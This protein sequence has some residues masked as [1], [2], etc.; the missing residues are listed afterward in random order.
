[1]ALSEPKA[2]TPLHR[3]QIT[4]DAFQRADGLTEIEATLVDTKPDDFRL[5]IERPHVP[6][7]EAIHRI[8]VRLAVDAESTIRECEVAMEVTP[9]GYCRE[10]EARFDLTG[11]N[12]GKGFIQ[13]VGER[14]ASA[15]NC[16][17][18]RQL[19]PQMATVLVQ[20][21]YPALRDRI[22]KLPRHER[23]APAMLNTCAGWQSHR[24]HIRIEHADHYR[25]ERAAEPDPGLA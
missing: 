2:R 13:A 18:A 3:R 5:G 22:A 1:M 21:I 4:L 8:A 15:D 20:A 16:W 12:L 7:G 17:H 25:P 11:L 6:A 9:Y 10:V 14:L 24:P 23:P 19:L